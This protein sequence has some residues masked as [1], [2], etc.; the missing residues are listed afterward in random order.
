[1][2]IIHK[3]SDQLIVKS[4]FTE[5][6]GIFFISIALLILGLFI[7]Y[8]PEFSQ[9]SEQKKEVFMSLT[10]MGAIL[11]LTWA[12]SGETTWIFDKNDS[13]LTVAN[14][15]LFIFKASNKYLLGEINEVRLESIED[16]GIKSFG[17]N[18][19]TRENQEIFTGFFDNSEEVARDLAREISKFLNLPAGNSPV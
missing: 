1:M 15:Y 17:V 12:I 18:I 4:S 6:S 10:G 8:F 16:D 2:K 5:T 9:N 19:F 11:L 14:S 3:T 13:Y 7:F